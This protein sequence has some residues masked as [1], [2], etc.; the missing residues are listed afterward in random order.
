[1]TLSD[2]IKEL[3]DN[4]KV[5]FAEIERTTG[6]SNGQI[7]RWTETSPKTETLQKVADYFGVSLDY[8]AGRTNNPIINNNGND[9]ILVAAHIIDGLS[10]DE[11]EE[12]KRYIEFIKSKH[13]K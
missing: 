8:L 4:K 3:A 9:D 6:I 1:M 13:S 5:T 2:R 12:V 7:R 10:D 11:L